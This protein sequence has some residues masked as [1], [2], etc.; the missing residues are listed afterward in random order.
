M[1]VDGWMNP[2]W[3]EWTATVSLQ[4]PRLSEQA[5]NRCNSGSGWLDGTIRWVSR[6]V[7]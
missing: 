1:Q 6:A 2:Y 7:R 5:W 3:Q 4:H